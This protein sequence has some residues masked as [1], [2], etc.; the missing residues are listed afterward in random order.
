[1][2]RLIAVAVAGGALLLAAACSDS[3]TPSAGTSASAAPA[4][5]DPV[6]NT[7]A[8]CKTADTVY[9]NLDATAKAELAKGAAAALSGDDAAAKKALE[10]VEPILKAASAT[11]QSE[12]DKAVDPN[13]KTALKTLADEYLQASQIQSIDDFNKIDTSEAEATLKS[14]CSESGVTLQHF[15]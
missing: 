6:A 2:K 5:T 15:E 13:V 14:L 7:A 8:A 10:T 4:S 11:L 9:A 3:S 12:S 1:M